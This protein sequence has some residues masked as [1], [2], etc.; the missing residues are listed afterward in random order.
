MTKTPQITTIALEAGEY[1]ASLISVGA[2]LVSLSHRQRN[3][4]YPHPIDRV[5]V[6]YQ[7]QVLLPWPNR[8]TDGVYTYN[9]TRYEVAINDHDNNAALHGLAFNQNWQADMVSESTATFTTLIPA[10]TGYPFSLS[11][12]TTYSLSAEGGLTVEIGASNIGSSVAP[13]GVSSHPYLTCNGR[14]VDECLLTVPAEEVVRAGGNLEPLG[15]VPTPAEGLDFRSPALIGPREIDNAFCGLPSEPWSV[16]LTDPETGLTVRMTATDQWVQVFSGDN[17]GR[18][19]LAVEPMTCPPDAF[20]TGEDVIL[21]EPC[22]SYTYSYS[23]RAVD[24]A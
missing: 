1:Q 18:R 16:D 5:P 23:I 22:Q 7:G 14:L 11:A 19:G 15:V 3:L 10:Q 6:G 2:G 12:W 21:L 17:I 9:G 24:R 13:Y 4:V 8:I 20:N